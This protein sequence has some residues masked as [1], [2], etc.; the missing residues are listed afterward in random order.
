MYLNFVSV[1]SLTNNFNIVLFFLIQTGSL[2]GQHFRKSGKMIDLSEQN[3]VDCS[4]S[5]GNNGCQGGL[6]D[7]AFKYIKDNHGIDTETSYPYEAKVCIQ[8]KH[9]YMYFSCSFSQ[10]VLSFSKN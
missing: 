4:K 10:E 3:L 5:Y 2:E 1:V 7:N 8:Y 6:M 9:T